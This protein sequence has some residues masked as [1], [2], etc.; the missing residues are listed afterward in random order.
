MV[1]RGVFSS[2]LALE[3]N[4]LRDLSSCSNLSDMLLKA[5]A[6]PANSLLPRTRTRA[7]RSPLLMR[8]MPSFN[9]P[10]GR[11]MVRSTSR[12]TTSTATS[13]MAI[14]ERMRICRSRRLS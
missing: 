11:V 2:W 10:M 7:D 4:W 8:E 12:S 5:R 14:Q 3:T 9:S 13:T 1:L 6:R